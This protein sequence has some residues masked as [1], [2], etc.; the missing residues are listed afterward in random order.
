M[1][2]AGDGTVKQTTLT[3]MHYLNFDQTF[4]MIKQTTH[5]ERYTLVNMLYKFGK[6]CKLKISGIGD[7]LI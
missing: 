1:I 3:G 4:L 7:I 2:Y 5:G 6:R